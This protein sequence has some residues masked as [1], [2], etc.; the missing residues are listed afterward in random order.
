MWPQITVS[1]CYNWIDL[2]VNR[3]VLTRHIHR[4]LFRV[5]IPCKDQFHLR[6]DQ[7]PIQ[8]MWHRKCAIYPCLDELHSGFSPSSE[9]TQSDNSVCLVLAW[10][11]WTADML[12]FDK[13]PWFWSPFG[14]VFSIEYT[15]KYRCIA[16]QYR[17]FL[18]TC[19]LVETASRRRANFVV[20]KYVS[21]NVSRGKS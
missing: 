8:N 9:K 2:K 20:K 19:E 7:R 3:L 4:S 12:F 17:Q 13:E 11:L 18:R 6:K 5:S 10:A 1:Q 21:R 16:V 14:L 15:G